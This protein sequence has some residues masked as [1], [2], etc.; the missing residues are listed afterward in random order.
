MSCVVAIFAYDFTHLPSVS[1]KAPGF[2]K[3]CLGGNDSAC[4][5]YPVAQAADRNAEQMPNAFFDSCPF[6]LIGMLSLLATLALGSYGFRSTGRFQGSDDHGSAT[7]IGAIL[8]LGVA[9]AIFGSCVWVFAWCP[10]CQFSGEAQSSGAWASLG[11]A[12]VE[13]GAGGQTLSCR[14]IVYMHNGY[15]TETGAEKCGL[16]DAK[17][18]AEG[19][20]VGVSG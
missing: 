14:P 19:R 7:T 18:N 12:H 15:A 16:I 8:C 3:E 5:A 6:F 1:P 2:E 10:S 9:V 13:H 4:R 20:G 11:P 17:L